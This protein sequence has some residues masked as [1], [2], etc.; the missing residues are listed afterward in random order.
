MKDM[1]DIWTYYVEQ[2]DKGDPNWQD[3]WRMARNQSIFTTRYG[4]AHHVLQ[5]QK[6][7]WARVGWKSSL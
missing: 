1:L 4:M 6:T 5:R 7:Q 3:T 2:V